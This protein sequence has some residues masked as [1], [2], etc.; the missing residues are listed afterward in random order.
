MHS[1]NFEHVE[2]SGTIA[3]TMENLYRNVRY[4]L[5]SLCKQPLFTAVVIC[6]L[7]LGIGANTAIFSVVNAVLL[8]PLP[9]ANPGELVV[10]SAKNEKKNIRQQPLS[11]PTV[12]DLQQANSVFQYL[13]A[14]RGE[15]FSLTDRDEPERVTG[16][17]VSANILALLG[18]SPALGRG[19]LPEEGAPGKAAVAM[20]GRALWQR[21]YSADPGVIGQAIIIDGKSYTVVGI[22]PAWLKQPGITLASLSDVDVWIPV[23]P[24][25]NEQNRNFANMRTVARLK[26]GVPLARAQSE[27]DTL[28]A[29]L[30]RQYPESNM[31]VRFDVVELRELLTGRVRKALWILLGAVGCIL[32]IACANVANLL[33]ARAASRQSEF[34]VR[35]ALGASRIQLIR[36]LFT[37]CLILS[38]SGGALGLLLG[39]CGVTLMISLSSGGVPRADEI[40]INGGVLLFTLLVCVLTALICGVLPAHQ[41]S[42]SDLNGDLKEAKKGMSGSIRH[43][44]TLN[45]LVVIEIALAVVLVAGAG[46]MMRS[47]RSVLS[48]DPG[49]DPRNVLTFSAALPQ[50]TYKDQQQHLQFFDRGLAKIQALPGVQSAAGTFRVPITGFAT[51]IFTIQ[52]KPVP[53]GQEPTADYRAITPAYFHAMGI[54]LLKGREFS[55]HDNAEAADAVIVNDELAR[56]YW[57]GEDPLGKRLQVGTELTRWR[58]V[59]GVVGNAKLSGLEAKVD[60]AVY[61]PFPQNSWPNALRNSFIVVRAAGNPQNLIPAIRQELRSIDPSLPIAQIRTMDEIVGESLSQR[62]FNTALLVLFASLAGILAALGVYGVMAY[63]V[64]QRTREMGIRMAL[65]AKDSDIKKL[66]ISNA[67]TLAFIG[68]AGG[69]VAAALSGQLLSSLLFAVTATDPITFVFTAV[70]LGAVTL[71]ASYIP[72]RRAANTDPIITLR[73][74]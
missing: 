30:E 4:A 74:N 51:V 59:V 31:N 58:E 56:R 48:I 36:E 14:V 60:P 52:G 19:F 10:L 61:I 44:R 66:M 39:Y 49:F 47:F 23:V 25:A 20:L 3:R 27:L 71:L 68:I 7:A 22:L 16:V 37:E 18:V 54:R 62:R 15:S 63:G 26:P 34:G 33:L 21:R 55:D 5:R 45:A 17:R 67:A 24:A 11:Y 70:L 46:L 50:A 32:L 12:V 8:S 9:Y 38:L 29:R 65:G 69:I 53:A 6:T 57:P 35:T 40:G 64:T 2:Q 72:S 41:Y 42:R 73:Y 28:A 43:R 13:S 1:I